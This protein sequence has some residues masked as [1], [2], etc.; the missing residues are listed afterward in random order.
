MGGPLEAIGNICVAS[1]FTSWLWPMLPHYWPIIQGVYQLPVNSKQNDLVM[2]SLNWQQNRC[3]TTVSF[4][5]VILFHMIARYW[6]TELFTALTCSDF[7]SSWKL[8]LAWLYHQHNTIL[9]YDAVIL[10]DQPFVMHT[11]WYNWHLLMFVDEVT[12]ISL[13]I[14]IDIWI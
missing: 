12:V 4:C 5:C 1:I 10:I 8:H 9:L 7:T 2:Q 6:N 3:G 11:H 14:C 13:L